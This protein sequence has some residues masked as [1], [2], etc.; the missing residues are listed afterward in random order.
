M[1]EH[2]K[3]PRLLRRIL[4]Q[5]A[6][7]I[8]IFIATLFAGGCASNDVT[9][10]PRSVT[11]QLLISTAMD[12]ALTNGDLSVFNGK[13]VFVDASYFDSYDQKYALGTI[14]DA[15]SSAGALLVDNI[16]NSELVVEA[17]AGALSVD[18]DTT[19]FGIPNMG[20]PIPLAGA[21][22]IPELA[23]YKSEKQNSIGKIALLAYDTKSRKHYYSTGSMLGKSHNYY[24]EIFFISWVTT[25][26]PEKQKNEKKRERDSVDFSPPPPAS[27]GLPPP[28]NPSPWPAASAPTLVPSGPAS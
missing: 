3:R 16:T 10:P 23:F 28:T 8:A 22:Q 2:Q 11:E 27:A 12:R 7:V 24:H 26:I 15:L 9:N 17:R 20:I 4:S 6:F 5:F 18:Y 14:R 19:L 13:K 1:E 25:D 21:L